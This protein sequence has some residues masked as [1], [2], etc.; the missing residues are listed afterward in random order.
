LNAFPDD[1]LW[2]A[3]TSAYPTEGGSFDTDWWRWEQRPGRIADGSSA[4]FAAGHYARFE[5]DLDLVRKLGHRAHLFCLDWGRIEPSRG[6]F[7]GEA[8]DHYHAVLDSLASRGI[9]P[10]CALHHTVLPAWL[11]GRGG[12]AHARAPSLFGR[13]A[14]RV[15]AEYAG[16]CRWWIPLLE[17]M[18]GLSMAY[19][20]R[21]WPPGSANLVRAA[22]ALR[23]LVRAHGAACGSLRRHGTG[24]KVGVSMRGRVFA[25][26]D[27]NS[28]WD[29]RAARRE[30]HRCNHWFPEA[31]RRREAHGEAFDFFALS[32]YGAERIRFSA[33]RPLRLFRSL[34]DDDGNALPRPRPVPDP[35]G[36][37]A[38][39]EDL[40]RYGVPLIIAGNGVATA[41]DAL[42]CRFL[43]DHAAT[44]RR[45]VGS[46]ADIRGYFH[47]ALLDGFEWDQG[48]GTRYGLVHVDPE[49]LART[50]NGSAYLFRDICENNALRPGVI[51]RFCPG[52][53]TPVAA[54]TGA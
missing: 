9:E 22:S 35:A 5:G 17:P 4:K 42:R 48:T 15:A 49:T 21:A 12:W 27:P 47:Y 14:A 53:Q 52:W 7:D 39:V 8:I 23:N 43:L 24:V 30:Q 11:A 29:L 50:P 38:L 20:E 32:Y 34:V 16:H 44:V 51:E 33:G 28:V 36:L 45:C 13:Y 10:V 18:Y 3:A 1:F 19:I 26:A 41:D 46:G 54:G 25:P 40:A 37:G 31:L 2:G 6:R